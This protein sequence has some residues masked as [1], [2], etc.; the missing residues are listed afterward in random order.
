MGCWSKD[1]SVFHVYLGHVTWL[2]KRN[3]WREGGS[4][5]AQACLGKHWWELEAGMLTISRP[6][7]PPSC[8]SNFCSSQLCTDASQQHLACCTSRVLLSAQLPCHRVQETSGSPF[9]R[10]S[11]TRAS[12]CGTALRQHQSRCPLWTGSRS[13]CTLPQKPQQTRRPL[14]AKQR[15]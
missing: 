4:G 15:S 3:H 9:H 2:S 12:P 11:A 13:P 10:K 5:K 1:L 6:M 14:P 7:S 8:S